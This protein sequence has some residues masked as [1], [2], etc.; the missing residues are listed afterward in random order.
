MAYNIYYNNKSNRDLG[1]EVV[2]RPYI[3][4][5]EKNIK[6][7]DIPGRDGSYYVDNGSYNDMVISI[8]F[9]FVEDRVD[10]I[11][12]RIREIKHYFEDKI[13]N[14]LF[15]SDNLDT[16]FRV[17]KVELDNISY[18]DFYEIQQFTVDFTVEAYEYTLNG[19]NEI[20]ATNEIFNQ[21][22]ISKPTYRIV[23]SGTCYLTINGNKIKCI[24]DKEL[25]I[26]TDNDKILDSNKELT[27]GKTNIKEMKDLYLQSGKNTLSITNNFVL[28]VKTN[29]R[30]I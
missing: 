14:R 16:F 5:P 28:Y 2:K 1:I 26:D 22:D 17:R 27:I 8:D 24:V 21:F 9:N 10:D 18:E 11:R 19:Q 30:T 12:E 3:P 15:L 23:G 29:F 25:T 13:D 20:K 7:I 4:F 6:S